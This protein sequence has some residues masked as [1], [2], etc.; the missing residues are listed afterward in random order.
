M[1]CDYYIYFV[2]VNG[3]VRLKEIIAWTLLFVSGLFA[4]TFVIGITTAVV[5]QFVLPFVVGQNG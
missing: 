2:G 1:G 4:F 5:L 3:M